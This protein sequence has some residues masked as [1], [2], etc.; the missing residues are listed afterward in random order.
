MPQEP[1]DPPAAGGLSLADDAATARAGAAL[2]AA[3]RPGDAVMLAGGL[4][5]G[6]TALARAAIASRL[7]AA[8]RPAEEIPSPTF[9]LVQ[10][11]EA[12][13]PIWHADLYR[14][15]GEDEVWELGLVDAFEAA[16]V[17]VEWPERL[18]ALAPARRLEL[19]L[20]A[21]ETGGRSLAWRALGG[22]WERVAAA[23]RG[24]A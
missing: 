14:L 19:S 22:G 4:G 20:A 17:F 8:G 18:G 7:A 5:A 16:I 6:K 23:L 3:L 2:G 12:D 9:T 13:A 15:P 21:P 11:Y 10:I 24:L 1:A